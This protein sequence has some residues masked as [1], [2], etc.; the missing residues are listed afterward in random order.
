MW[1]WSLTGG[2]TVIA[3][4]VLT[5]AVPRTAPAASPIHLDWWVFAM[6]FLVAEV[7]VI[8]LPVRREVHTISLS[9]IPLMVGLAFASPWAVI[10]G[11]LLGGW[12]VLWL[13]RRNPPIKLFFNLALFA[14]EAS[15]AISVYRAILG[16]S[17]P[18]EPLGWVAA[19]IALVLAATASA[20]MVDA[21]IAI[22]QSHRR[23]SDVARSFAS[24]A[25]TSIAAALLGVVAVFLLWHDPRTVGLLGAVAVL[26]FLVIRV[27]SRLSKRYDELQALYGFTTG[28]DP[29][30]ASHEIAVAALQRVLTTM[31]AEWAV[32]VLVRPD[33]EN[34]HFGVD[35]HGPP[36]AR[37]ADPGQTST[38]LTIAERSAAERRFGPRSHDHLL[39]RTLGGAACGLLAPIV[40][41]TDPIGALIVT[42]RT[43]PERE[44]APTDL[45]L[46]DALAA[47]TSVALDRAFAIERLQ[48]EVVAKQEVI[49]SKDQ[50]IAAVSHELRTPLTG[51]LGFAEMLRDDQTGYTD[52]EIQSMV[53]AIANDALGLTNLVEDLLTAARAQTGSI[54]VAPRPVD[55][56][57]LASLVAEEHSSGGLQITVTGPV[58]VAQAD[59]ARVRQIVRNLLSNAIRYGGHKIHVATF[60]D[61]AGACLRVA[62]NGDGIPESDQERVFAAY[63]SAHDPGTQPGSLGLGLTIS[64]SL[65]RLMAGD[66]S[67]RRF[68]GWTIF[69]MQLPAWT[70]TDPTPTPSASTMPRR[71]HETVAETPASESAHP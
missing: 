6:A 29:T 71:E 20:A 46:L 68:D 39:R 5:F 65:A 2:M 52:R 57:A 18:V 28:V 30:L 50:L 34:V 31:Q 61:E 15:V 33:G 53:D 54:T 67:Y 44:F 13:R 51:V 11:R 32:I 25:L 24:G 17:S 70:G 45:V 3:G 12:V 62:D 56:R 23:F 36:T 58:V 8:H 42:G 4:V 49:Q 63:E 10:L 14:L 41:G 47:Q 37:A 43:G 48:D 22:M 26:F 27:Y 35:V 16:A 21:A 69:E 55:L 38:L 19:C 40:V 60:S 1:V 9:E 64:R 59:E 66:L 7:T